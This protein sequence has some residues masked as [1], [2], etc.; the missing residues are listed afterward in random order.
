MA[1]APR[2]AMS[3]DSSPAREI[4]YCNGDEM[5]AVAVET[6]PSFRLSKPE[7]LFEGRYEGAATEYMDYAKYD[8]T[9]D[10]QRFMIRSEEESAPTRIH[11]VLNW[12]EELKEK[13]PRSSG[14][15][16]HDS[17]ASA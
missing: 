3:W 17:N 7:I 1:L 8:V 2:D 13:A 15:R 4:F 14:E 12:T 9:P 10:G 16:A 11:V 5:M 6:T